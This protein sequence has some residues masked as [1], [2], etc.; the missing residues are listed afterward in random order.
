MFFFIFS[1]KSKKNEKFENKSM[2]GLI[3]QDDQKMKISCKPLMEE[4]R[5]GIHETPLHGILR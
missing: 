1:K 4:D 3:W 5:G 2:S